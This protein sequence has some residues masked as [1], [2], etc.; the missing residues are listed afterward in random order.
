MLTS[1]II[2]FAMMTRKELYQLCYDRIKILY[3]EGEAA[4]M[5][6]LLMEKSGWKPFPTMEQS[7]STEEET[8]Y[9]IEA[10][11]RLTRHEPIQYITGTAWFQN[12]EFDVNPGV[13]IPRPE[14]EELVH[15]AL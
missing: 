3:G 6:R 5:V 10:I 11:N 9:I 2:M 1:K 14:T 7:E 15:E 13:L 12:M 8:G 4:A